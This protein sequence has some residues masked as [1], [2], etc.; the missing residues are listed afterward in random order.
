[1]D[2]LHRERIRTSTFIY[3]C[4]YQASSSSS[5]LCFL[6]IFCFMWL[7]VPF[8]H[9]ADVEP[10]NINANEASALRKAGRPKERSKTAGQLAQIAR[11]NNI[12]LGNGGRY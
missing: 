2:T 5:Q 3:V 11:D 12:P 10:I 4:I 8:H 9:Y 1:M 7:I 6:S